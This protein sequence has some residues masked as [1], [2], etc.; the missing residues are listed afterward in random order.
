MIEIL[1]VEDNKADVR[2][3]EELLKATEVPYH[4]DVVTNG[5]DAIRYLRKEGKYDRASR[6]DL[7]ILDLNLPR[8]NGREFLGQ[9]E[10]LLDGIFVLI[11]SGSPGIGSSESLPHKRM[12][13]PSTNEEFDETVSELRQLLLLL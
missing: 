11:F 9:A 8:L 10:D 2:L 6:P 1:V 7:I 12:T 3:I 4:S 5:E 13:K